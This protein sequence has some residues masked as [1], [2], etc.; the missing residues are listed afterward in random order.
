M[1][2]AKTFF[3]LLK[4]FLGTGLLLMAKGFANG[5]YAFSLVT[6]IISALISGI[7]GQELIET[8]SKVR[9]SFS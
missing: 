9:G 1:G 6:L 3:T 2:I 7:A 8:R 4:S 5:G